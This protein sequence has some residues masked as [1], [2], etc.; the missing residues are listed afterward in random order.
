VKK[1][2]TEMMNQFHAQGTRWQTIDH[3]VETPFFVDSQLS[4]MVQVAD[5]CGYV[6]RRY[7]ERHENNALGH[8][9]NELF[10]LVFRRADRKENNTVGVRHFTDRENA[11]GCEI[12]LGH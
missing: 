6:L 10:D 9:D 1:K 2:H 12:C 8:Y 7:L 4:N 5:L 11:C 3:I